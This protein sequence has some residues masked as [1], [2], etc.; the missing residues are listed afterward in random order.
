MILRIEDRGYENYYHW[1]IYMFSVL[2]KVP[3]NFIVDKIYSNSIDSKKFQN[4][5]LKM[6][7]PNAEI[8]NELKDCEVYFLSD[9]F[10]SII[11]SD[12]YK[13]IRNKL[14]PFASDINYEYVFISRKI[15]N[16]SLSHVGI[17]SRHIK[18]EIE[19]MARLPNFKY[20]LME[21]YSLSDQIGIFKNAKIIIAAHGAALTN[22]CFASSTTNIIEIIP[23]NNTGYSNCKHFSHICEALNIPY[24]KFTDVYNIVDGHQDM[25]VDIEKLLNLIIKIK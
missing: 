1:F 23:D 11:D 7:Y 17:S 15:N 4:K 20:I 13:F 18:N 9:N 12:I 25:D 24:H 16:E 2:R 10:E 22:C 6:I 19:L 14:L 5:S 8:V 3:V 21:E